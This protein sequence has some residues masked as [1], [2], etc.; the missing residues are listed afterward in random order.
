MVRRQS[1][2]RLLR[3]LDKNNVINALLVLTHA[4]LR[5]LRSIRHDAENYRVS[6]IVGITSQEMTHLI[7]RALASH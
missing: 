2:W 6:F 3:S 5:K 4:L 1:G 7:Y